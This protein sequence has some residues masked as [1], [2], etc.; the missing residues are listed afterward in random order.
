MANNQSANNRTSVEK[1]NSV[2]DNLV[3]CMM[4]T[5]SG[6]LPEWVEYIDLFYYILS[7]GKPWNERRYQK[8]DPI[9]RRP[10]IKFILLWRRTAGAVTA[11]HLPLL[12]CSYRKR[13][14]TDRKVTFFTYHFHILLLQ[15]PLHCQLLCQ[16]NWNFLCSPP[17]FFT[18]FFLTV[19]LMLDLNTFLLVQ[20]GD[21][22]T[23]AIIIITCIPKYLDLRPVFLFHNKCQRREVLVCSLYSFD[24]TIFSENSQL[25]NFISSVLFGEFEQVSEKTS[26]FL[27]L[28]ELRGCGGL[29]WSTNFLFLSHGS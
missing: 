7:G 25:E 19:I 28:L 27:L 15:N 10:A 5:K 8:H 18:F 21:H 24:K 3:V 14:K 22:L 1:V 23:L 13:S 2:L 17:P 12:R 6:K 9:E 20:W 16:H 11:S 4:T 29:I 26:Q